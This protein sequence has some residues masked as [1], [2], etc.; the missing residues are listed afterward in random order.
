[1]TEASGK[2]NCMFAMTKTF[3]PLLLLILVGTVFC[4][5]ILQAQ[6]STQTADDDRHIDRLGEVSTDEWQLD[7]A[8]PSAAPAA[9]ERDSSFSLPN[10]QQNRALQQLLS[11]IGVKPGDAKLHTQLNAL[12]VDVLAQ[13]NDM[14]VPGSFDQA[15]QMLSLIQSINPDF[16]GLK[17][18][19]ARIKIL[20]EAN[21]LVISGNFALAEQKLTEPER[22]NAFYFY[23]QSLG[24]HP[25]NDLAQQGIVNVQL[26]L[27]QRAMDSSQDMDFDLAEE[28]LQ[29]ASTIL[30]DQRLVDKA[31]AEIKSSQQDRAAVLEQ[32][33][34]D[35]MNAGEF[36]LADFNIIDLI[37]L[38]GHQD[39][40]E[41][42]RRRLKEARVYGGFEPGQIIV[43]DFLQSEHKAPTI[44]PQSFLIL[45]TQVVETC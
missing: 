17:N 20:R 15:A 27:I 43:D 3:N 19:N 6:E 28:W 32:N 8:L 40:E 44:L 23:R 24:K 41:V 34:I 25:Q 2:G 4:V 7:L 10:E 21:D 16:S 12:L 30:D 9:A 5:P 29:E 31:R 42:L 45:Q 35:A 13:A 37:A 39:R 26:G 14:M 22:D 11:K 36:T 38:G 1:M 33:A 18:A